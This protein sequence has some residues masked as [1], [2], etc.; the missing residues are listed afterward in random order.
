MRYFPI[1]FCKSIRHSLSVSF[2]L[3]AGL[4]PWI[5]AP[6]MGYSGDRLNPIEPPAGQLDGAI[7]PIPGELNIIEMQIAQQ[8][9]FNVDNVRPSRG[10]AGGFSRGNACFDDQTEALSPVALV[11]IDLSTNFGRLRVE[12]TVDD[13]PTFYIFLPDMDKEPTFGELL[14]FEQDADSFETIIH[15]QLIPLPQ[16]TSP[17]YIPVNLAD[18]FTLET[19]TTYR[20]TVE[21]LCSL[22]DRSSNVFAEGWVERVEPSDGLTAVLDQADPALHPELYATAGHWYDTLEALATLWQE[23]PNDS[24]L[25]NA[26]IELLTSVN[27]DDVAN[28]PLLNPASPVPD[29]PASSETE[30]APDPRS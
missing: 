16:T 23:N 14:I 17:G 22:E 10:R 4:A 7:V 29:Q 27:L 26:W 12:T 5:L 2:G 20:W 24:T 1:W 6:A 8:L 15:S 9:N 11:P 28:Y 18:D 21:I 13:Q 25:R 19:D 3:V 30:A